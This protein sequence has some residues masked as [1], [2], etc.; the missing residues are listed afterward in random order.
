MYNTPNTWGNEVEDASVLCNPELIQ[1]TG[2][3]QGYNR[4][5]EIGTIYEYNGRYGRGYVRVGGRLYG[6]ST[7]YMHIN[8]YVFRDTT[9]LYLGLR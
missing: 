6:R 1:I 8:Y 7:N 9:P 5:S 3:M 2:S 4:V